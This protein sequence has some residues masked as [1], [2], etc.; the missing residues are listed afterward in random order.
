MVS[1]ARLVAAATLLLGAA[2]V[3]GAQQPGAGDGVPGNV[4]RALDNDIFSRETGFEA[5]V[6][7]EQR[8][9]EPRAR[10]GSPPPPYPQPPP[11]PPS[12][13]PPPYPGRK[14]S[15]KPRDSVYASG[16]K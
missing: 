10:G 13:P 11:Y 15:R 1:L 7:L 16:E 2:N 6:D 5:M 9:L 4:E 14:A 12:P 8:D 3:A